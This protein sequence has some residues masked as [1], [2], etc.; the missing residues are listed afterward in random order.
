MY[1]DRQVAVAK[2][3]AKAKPKAKAK[4]TASARQW[5]E[6]PT[7]AGPQG[8]LSQF[9]PQLERPVGRD[10]EEQRTPGSPTHHEQ[11]QAHCPSSTDYYDNSDNSQAPQYGT[12]QGNQHSGSHNM[13]GIQYD[14][15]DMNANYQGQ[16]YNHGQYSYNY[17]IGNYQ[18]YT[19]DAGVQQQS[20]PIRHYTL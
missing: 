13:N 2:A 17:I 8:L 6:N 19:N 10:A 16:H 11:T 20:P 14:H 18:I 12:Q 5:V 7:A 9:D 1:A 15:Y 4:A 3:K